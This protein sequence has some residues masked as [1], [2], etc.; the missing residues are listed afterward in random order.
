V[1]P[2]LADIGE[3]FDLAYL[4]GVRDAANLLGGNTGCMRNSPPAFVATIILAKV[5]EQ[6]TMIRGFLWRMPR[7]QRVTRPGS[8]R[9]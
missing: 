4:A 1:V 9:R 3:R 8:C 6:G 5:S 2:T 7:M